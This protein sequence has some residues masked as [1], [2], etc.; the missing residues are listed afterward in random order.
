VVDALPG[1]T[2]DIVVVGGGLVGLAVAFGLVREGRSVTI[3]DEGD[4]AFRASRGNFALVWT[5]GKG[6]G[7]PAYTMW[8]RQSA[9][10]WTDFAREIEA[11]SGVAVHHSQRGGFALALSEAEL[12]RRAATLARIDAQVAGWPDVPAAPSFEILDLPAL[13]AAMPEIG[14]EVVGGTFSP[15]DGHVNSLALFRALHTG[16]A[17]LGGHYLPDRRVLAIAPAGGGFALAT[18]KGPLRAER[19]VLA[20]GIDNA[21]LAP[22]V[23]LIAPVRPQ[24]GQIVVT[25]KLKPFLTRPVQ[26]LRQTDEGGVMIGGSIEE[27]GT[28]D[29]VLPGVV[30]AIARRAV[31]YFP[32]LAGVN[33][34]RTWA[35]L[36]IMSQDGFPIYDQSS[37]HPGAFICT[38]HSGVTLAAMHALVVAPAIAQGSLSAAFQPFSASR[39]HVPA[40]A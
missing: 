10:L 30:G 39:F 25:E 5:Q 4:V 11:V 20:A 6:L 9:R 18:G 37:A 38:C 32:H 14:P 16:F 27:V 29:H 26:T 3:L 22:M 12:S 8:T 35:A 23:G 36:R 28:D 15:L 19:V 1:E 2:A 24:R 7:L 21:R 17:K 33:V 31:K 34:V 13:R 40:T